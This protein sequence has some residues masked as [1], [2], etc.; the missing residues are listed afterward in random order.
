[1]GSEN[2]PHK[3]SA[4]TAADGK[5]AVRIFVALKITPDIANQL[6]QL[7]RGL[8]RFPVRFIAPKDIHLTLV[9]P[10]HEAS[11][12][13]A[14]EKL[15]NVAEKAAPFSL[16]FVSLTYGPQP[17]RARLLW[18][19]CAAGEE[20][21]TL[22]TALL[23]AFGQVD[24][25]PFRPHVTLAR[26]RG[27]GAAVARKHPMDRAPTIAVQQVET[28]ELMQSPPAGEVGY[29]VLASMRLGREPMR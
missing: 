9:P 14:V 16:S 19:E 2:L 18:A 15:R 20:L 17:R 6:A 3:S 1:M 27:Y 12:P 7:A 22:R 28:V 24:D 10:W 25:R 23:L 4:A 11:L 26:I 8:E 21:T 13:T 5:S 29:R